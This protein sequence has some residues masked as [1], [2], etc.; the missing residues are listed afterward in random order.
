MTVREIITLDSR[1]SI[2]FPVVM[3]SLGVLFFSMLDAVMKA[4][5]LAMG[6]Y[7]ATFWRAAMGAVFASALYLPNRPQLATGRVLRL[8]ITRGVLTA[9]MMLFL[10]WSLTQ[11]PL[12]QAIGLSFVAPI[13]ALY[14][15]A[16]M[17]GEEITRGAKLAAVLGFGGVLVIAGEDM[18]QVRDDSSLLGI[19]AV[20]VFAIMYALNII[21]QRKQA[22]VARP[23]EIAC[24]QNVI[25]TCVLTL[26]VPFA[27]SLPADVIQWTALSAA[28][29]LAV[30]SLI[31]MSIAYRR[32]EAQALVSVEY[33]AFIWAALFG[34][35]FFAEPV[36]TGTLMGT[37]LIVAGCIISTRKAKA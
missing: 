4:Q 24:Y 15:A 10:F 29:V 12:A 30:I 6:A 25:M 27:V 33:T 21:L 9:F 13:I 7:S 28:G 20:L 1:N 18:F 31:L 2:L 5:A 8:H 11:L 23:T 14:L 35:L 19:A 34:W 22:L 17:L 3:A 37:A 36:S 16:P 26:G 32:A